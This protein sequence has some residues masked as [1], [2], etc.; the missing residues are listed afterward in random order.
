MINE[1]SLNSHRIKE[2]ADKGIKT[3]PVLIEKVIRALLL[4]EGLVE[5]EIKFVFKGGTSL[6]LMLDS[7]KRLSIDID[8]I[9]PFKQGKLLEKLETIAKKKGFSKVVLHQRKKVSNIKKEHYK[10]YYKA[11]CRSGKAESNILLDIL[12]E[13]VQ[14]QK[15][16]TIDID[17]TFLLQEGEPLK[18]PVPSF[19][20]ILGDK[21]TAFA[22]DTTGIPYEKQGKSMAME[23]I[24]Q[25]YDI[26]NVFDNV[27]N[28]KI[29]ASTF[30]KFAVT[31]LS[32][33]ELNQDPQL[34]LDDI[35]QTALSISTRG[36]KGGANFK[37][38]Q[39]GISKVKAFIFSESYHIEK[40]IVHASK[41]AY[42]T[43][44]IEYDA[45]SFKRFNNPLETED[46]IIEQP[47]HTNLNKLKKS[48]P[49]AF[50]YWFRVYEFE[51]KVMDIE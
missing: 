19:E 23:I 32:Y 12:F 38:L 1:K 17:S 4:L 20:D 26:G 46:W 7:V 40:A 8:I 10:F 29:I 25:L 45:T 22:P 44:L 18:V 39:E 50:F 11:S 31:E 41:A 35:F 30:N 16:N 5:S 42:L 36:K 6:M 47:F 13:E 9:I 48:N 27:K 49:E 43:K 24:K 14:Y 2:I 34:V 33:R 21:L 37:V 51:K 28:L 3:D 15:I